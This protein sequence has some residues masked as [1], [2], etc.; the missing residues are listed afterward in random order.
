MLSEV[1]TVVS[2]HVRASSPAA[3]VFTTPGS[4]AHVRGPARRR[5]FGLC[6]AVGIRGRSRRDAASPR[7]TKSRGE[8]PVG[9]IV[10]VVRV[11]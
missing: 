7:A 11:R 4:A 2:S 3:A 9:D 10:G 8:I 5:K 1:S 6:F